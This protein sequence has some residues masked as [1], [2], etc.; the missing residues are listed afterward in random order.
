[1]IHG[2]FKDHGNLFCT[3]LIFFLNSLN[4]WKLLFAIT[5]ADVQFNIFSI[6]EKYGII[7]FSYYCYFMR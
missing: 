4:Y 7:L 3:I 1:M 2:F 5:T 6:I